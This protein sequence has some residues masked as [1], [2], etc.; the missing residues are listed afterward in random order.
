[1]SKTTVSTANV[2]QAAPDCVRLLPGVVAVHSDCI[3][4]GTAFPCSCPAQDNLSLHAALRRAQPG[5]VIVCDAGGNIEAGYFG[6]LMGLDALNRGIV[7]LVINGAVRDTSDLARIGFP[8]FAAGTAPY[9]CHKE[10]LGSV[11]EAIILNGV[12]IRSGDVVVADP[13]AVVVIPGDVWGEVRERAQAISLNEKRVREQL[14]QGRNLADL[15]SL[16]NVDSIQEPDH[17]DA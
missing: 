17:D 13:D 2:A 7:G 3:A 12:P 6:E 14:A 16:S 8:V 1:M 10:R 9:Q 11:G 5:D 15:L 4:V